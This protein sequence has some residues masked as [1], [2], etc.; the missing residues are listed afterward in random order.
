MFKIVIPS[1]N[2]DNLNACLDSIALNEPMFLSADVIVVDDGLW[3]RGL[4]KY[5]LGVTFVQGQKPFNF[6]RNVNL[7]LDKAGS[8]D[9]I[10]LNDDTKLVTKFGFSKL[11]DFVAKEARL[12]VYS[13][14]IKGDVGNPNQQYTANEKELVREEL[15]SL[16]FVCVY[17][18]KEVLD[19]VGVLD[20]RFSGYGYED[21]DY[22]RRALGVG[23]KLVVWNGCVVEHSGKPTFRTQANFQELFNKNREIYAKKWND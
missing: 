6:A 20:E 15:G 5:H 10:V 23:A 1:K 9:V 13:P 4:S 19:E 3:L 7:G 8:S 18:K 21:N 17:L 16:M 2:V 22:C 12:A 11:R 14:G